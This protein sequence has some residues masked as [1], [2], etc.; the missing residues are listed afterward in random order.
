MLSCAGL[1]T[2]V[3]EDYRFENGRLTVVNHFGVVNG[4]IINIVSE[5]AVDGTVGLPQDVV[6]GLVEDQCKEEL[7]GIAG[8][9]AVGR[10]SIEGRGVGQI[11]LFKIAQIHR[12]IVPSGLVYVIVNIL[13]VHQVDFCQGVGRTITVGIILVEALYPALNV[14][15][16][17]VE[18]EANGACI[19]Q[20]DLLILQAKSYIRILF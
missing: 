12:Q 16:G 9:G 3:V 7:V 11:N 15:L 6:D 20:S 8:R 17:N 5:G 10:I 14:V 1:S 13:G 18:P 4:N 19:F 2:V